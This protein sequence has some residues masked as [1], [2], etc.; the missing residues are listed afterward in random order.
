MGTLVDL[1]R[2]EAASVGTGPVVLGAAVDGYR[3][4]EALT[5]G[6]VYS[7]RIQSGTSYEYGLGT[8]VL[9]SGVSKL[10]RGVVG[11][12][13]LNGPLNLTDG[14]VVQFE[15]L[16]SDFGGGGG[17]GSGTVTSVSGTG[18]VS[19]L[20][21]SGTVTTSG[22]LTLGGTLTLTSGNVTTALGYTPVNLSSL[23]TIATSGSA[24][25]LSTG[26]LLAAR[27]PALTG[28]VT[29]SAGT[30]LT[31]IAGGAVTLA[32]MANLAANSIIGNN[33]GSAATPLALTA[34]Q[35]KALLAI[36]AADVSGLATVA[37][38][39]SAADLTGNLA[40][41]R[42]NSGTSASASTFWRGDGTWGTPTFSILNDDASAGPVYLLFYTGAG[43][44]GTLYQSSAGLPY[45]PSTGGLKTKVHRFFAT[46][47]S[48]VAQN[49]SEVAIGGRTFANRTMP[50]VREATGPGYPVSPHVAFRRIAQAQFGAGTTVTTAAVTSGTM[51]YTMVSVTAPSIVNPTSAAPYLRTQMLT[52]VSSGNVPSWRSSA[53]VIAGRPFFYCFRFGPSIMTGGNPFV[54]LVDVNTAPTLIDPTTSTP[55]RMG[56]GI[57][58]GNISW[59]ILNNVTGTAATITALT[60]TAYS[61]SITAYFELMLWSDGTSYYWQVGNDGGSWSAGAGFNNQVNSGTFSS[62]VPAPGTLLYPQAYLGN[63]GANANIPLELIMVTRETEG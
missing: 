54:G 15:P 33:T 20:T 62:N 47:S 34:T 10:I 45:Y 35:T 53:P 51:P 63:P 4:Y 29:T 8:Y 42:L 60:G 21:L 37:T 31:T 57:G 7:Y 36:G 5:S 24:A 22:N 56:M 44:T 16:A 30:V 39:G 28:D 17:G 48:D 43:S 1:V 13:N 19:G 2:I 46:S 6:T 23:A 12:S 61:Q 41:A 40:V 58:G 50:T 25:D 14:S 9:A 52:T 26:T 3:G 27:M 49:A 32:K 59:R 55:G 18:T 38:S 11:S